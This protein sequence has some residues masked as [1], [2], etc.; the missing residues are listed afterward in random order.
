MR[1][2]VSRARDGRNR[3]AARAIGAKASPCALRARRVA[4]EP[5]VV[6]PKSRKR[7]VVVGTRP[8][9]VTLACASVDRGA[10]LGLVQALA[11][12]AVERLELGRVAGDGDAA[13]GVAE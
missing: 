1:R 13:G 7:H 8:N 11:A 12:P 5:D 4:R 2:N 9:T 10:G 6:A 3:P